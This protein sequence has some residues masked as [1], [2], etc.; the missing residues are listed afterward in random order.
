MRKYEVKEMGIPPGIN[1]YLCELLLIREM[2]TSRKKPASVLW[3]K[4]VKNED[5]VKEV[6]AELK[7]LDNEF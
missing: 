5:V 6:K 2:V 3:I 7:K 1:G 4:E